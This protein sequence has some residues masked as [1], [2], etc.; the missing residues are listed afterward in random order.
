MTEASVRPTLAIVANGAIPLLLVLTG[1][2]LVAVG[3]A[4]PSVVGLA[5]LWSHP[6]RRTYEHGYLIAAI[7]LWLVYRERRLVAA[8]A[9]P[10]ST[11]MI[12]VCCGLGLAWAIAYNAGLQ[13][14]HLVLWP[15]LLW[16][17]A[18]AAL[19]WRSAVVLLRPMAFIAFALPLWDALI[20]VLQSVTVFANQSLAMLLGMPV[21]IDG[22][23]I[24]IPEG[25]FEIAGGCSGLNYLV[26]GL[27]VAALLGEVNRDSMRRRLYL[28]VVSGLLALL[29]NWFRVFVII[30]AG[31]AS[32][33]THYLVRVD[34]YK[35]GWAVYTVVL[36][37][38]FVYARRLPPSTPEGSLPATPDRGE[39]WR[40]RLMPIAVAAA[41]MAFGPLWSG[42]FRQPPAASDINMAHAA[43]PVPPADRWQPTAV[44]GSWLPT[45]P[46]ADSETMIEYARDDRRVTVYVASY[47]RQSQGRELVGHSS[48]IEGAGAG[49]SLRQQH[50][51]VVDGSSLDFIEAH[52]Q[53]SFG[54]R[55]VL[56][57]AYRV[58]ERRFTSAWQAQFWYGLASLWSSPHSSILIL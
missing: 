4:W 25:S 12:A 10:V 15:M 5:E 21:I 16:S 44:S 11:A 52:R 33:M 50:R 53:D 36:V 24:H 27:A 8:A 47:L 18:G 28:L 40:L 51:I 3:A 57:W 49:R 30:Y 9:G 1:L 54:R 23:V 38:F 55:A 6:E 42:W 37:G 43:F 29:S 20:P 32:N 17:G 7:V 35:W 45:F 14:A 13:A 22:T 41:A 39:H 2:A 31:H 48:R 46:G 58:G 34:H 19:G 26:V 56:W